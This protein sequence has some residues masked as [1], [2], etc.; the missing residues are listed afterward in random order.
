MAAYFAKYANA[1]LDDPVVRDEV[2]NYFVGRIYL[3]D[4]DGRKRIVIT[5]WLAEH[6]GRRYEEEW[7]LGEWDLGSDNFAQGSTAK[8]RSLIPHRW[9]KGSFISVATSSDGSDEQPNEAE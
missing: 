1:N 7:K 9:N 4:D 3:Y 5:G 8:R 2:L 6:G